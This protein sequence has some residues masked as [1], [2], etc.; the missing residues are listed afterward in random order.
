MNFFN[1]FSLF[2]LLLNHTWESPNADKGRFRSKN[3]PLLMLWFLHASHHMAAFIYVYLLENSKRLS[4]TVTIDGAKNRSRKRFHL[5]YD[6]F[7]TSR[8]RK[9]FLMLVYVCVCVC[10]CWICCYCSKFRILSFC[11]RI[12][13]NTKWD[14]ARN[15]FFLRFLSLIFEQ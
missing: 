1:V 7:S 13:P 2:E 11:W 12:V 14:E 4:Q 10:I 8:W 5:I 6:I 9:R 15:P 3:I